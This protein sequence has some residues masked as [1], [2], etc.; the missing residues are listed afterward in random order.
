MYKLLCKNTASSRVA[1]SVV[2]GRGEPRERQEV[3]VK[4]G[5]EIEENKPS[6]LR[7][8]LKHLLPAGNQSLSLRQEFHNFSF[9]TG[10]D[11]VDTIAHAHCTE[12]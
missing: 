10:M 1:K 7:R 2:G 8:F 3:Y 12:V 6:M 9:R 11:H 4:Q 5:K